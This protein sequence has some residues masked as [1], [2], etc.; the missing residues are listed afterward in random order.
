MSKLNA[1]TLSAAIA[2]ALAPVLVEA[3][4]GD[5]DGGDGG[6]DEAPA[7][8]KPGRPPGSTKD[9]SAKTSKKP[10]ADEDDPLD[11]DGDDGD[12]DD[13]LGLDDGDDDIT[14]E[15]LVNAFK[16]LK[17]SHGVDKCREVLAKLGESNVLNIPAKRY[18]EAMKE[19]QRAA[20]KKK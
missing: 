1:K 6:D 16:A 12:G 13:G 9:K 17:A 7:K 11:D 5:S 4:G 8:K 20:T 10:P 18:N 15:E 2:A 19:V 14:Q 3:F